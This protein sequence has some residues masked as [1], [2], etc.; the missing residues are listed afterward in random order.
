M[1]NQNHHLSHL[2]DT[3]Y[4]RYSKLMMC[5]LVAK[6]YSHLHVACLLLVGLLCIRMYQ[7]S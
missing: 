1:L 5:L 3:V 2:H 6:V 7:Y 4:I